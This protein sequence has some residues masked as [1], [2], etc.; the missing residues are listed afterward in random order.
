MSAEQIV[1]NM[2]EKYNSTQD[3]SGVVNFTAYHN[4]A[5]E[6]TEFEIVLKKPDKFWKYDKDHGILMVSNGKK[7]WLYDEKTNTVMVKNVT[8]EIHAKILGYEVGDM[9]KRYDIQ[10][11]GSERIAERDCY[12][13]KLKPK[14]GL[15][16]EK[17]WIDKQFW[18]PIR[19]EIVVGNARIVSEYVNISFNTGVSDTKFEFV[20]PEGAR[21]IE[22][23]T[24][25]LVEPKDKYMEELHKVYHKIEDIQKMVNFTILK[26]SNTTG[27]VFSHG[28]IIQKTAD[29]ES[30]GL[31]FKKDNKMLHIQ[32]IYVTSGKA[33]PPPLVIPPSEDTKTTR[34]KIDG[35]DGI[36]QESRD[37]TSLGFRFDNVTVIMW[38]DISGEEMIKIAKSMIN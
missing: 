20:P 34:V 38:G 29:L 31:W 23:E 32:E 37:R 28:G 7:I 15:W 19:I 14:S 25:E 8:G 16:I 2:Q 35:V 36:L 30:V 11:L 17:M 22:V 27:Y 18:W 9:L 3:F 5:T 33:P 1:K 10:L 26:P 13:I 12:V 21:V 6:A 4:G 24:G